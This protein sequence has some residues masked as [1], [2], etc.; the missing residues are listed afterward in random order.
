MNLPF[1]TRVRTVCGHTFIP[2]LD[3]GST[4]VDLGANDGSF[5]HQIVQRFGARV[6]AVEP[7]PA[8]FARIPES[9]LVVRVNAAIGPADGTV[10][11][12]VANDSLASSICE[13]GAEQ[14][15][16]TISVASVSLETLLKNVGVTEIDLMKVDIE[17]AEREVFGSV[18][19][20]ILLN[21]TQLSIE[22]HDFCHLMS[23]D[24]VE[25]VRQRLIDLG[26]YEIRFPP[27]NANNLFI[28]LKR[29][30]SPAA[31]RWFVKHVS[32]NL[33]AMKRSMV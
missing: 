11:F 20:S 16:E 14:L 31:E 22:F 12:H 8:M 23:T 19:D 29:W 24:E 26:F 4:V 33:Q 17:G 3:R 7:S 25:R 6:I 21:T 30:R 28:N 9:A 18:P 15:K 2:R 13:I 27:G 32:R 10:R 5:A 1:L